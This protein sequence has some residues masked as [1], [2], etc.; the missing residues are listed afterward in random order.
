[1]AAAAGGR[2]DV[3]QHG[4]AGAA[5]EFRHPLGRGGPVPERQQHVSAI[6]RRP[7]P[8]LPGDDAAGTGHSGGARP[9]AAR[10]RWPSILMGSTRMKCSGSPSTQ[11]STPM[12]L[13]DARSASAST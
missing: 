5:E 12:L 7:A 13:I 11:D 10:M 4:H 9:Y 3:D 6:L 2:P 1:M 8:G